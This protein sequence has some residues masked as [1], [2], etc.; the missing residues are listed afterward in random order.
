[1]DQPFVQPSLFLEPPPGIVERIWDAVDR[2]YAAG[3]KDPP[4]RD[5]VVEFMRRVAP[6]EPYSLS[7]LDRARMKYRQWLEPWPIR[8]GQRRPW[9][10]PKS[11]VHGV[12]AQ[13]TE[14]NG[15]VHADWVRLTCSI[16]ANGTFADFN[17]MF[18]FVLGYS[19]E[20]LLHA[21]VKPLLRPNEDTKVTE[22][23]T[24]R[25][26]A[27]LRSGESDVE[28]ISGWMQAKNGQRIEISGTR[29][30]WST[31]YQRWDLVSQIAV[32]DLPLQTLPF[33]GSHRPEN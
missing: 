17:D 7:T 22:A 29:V 15:Q 12:V 4:K 18:A 14:R 26:L 10:Q 27:A 32:A 28:T 11:L 5:E 21:A 24:V 31:E 3:K 8:R 23:E 30:T 33:F 19:R 25:K 2:W 13:R 16:A 1:M 20:E 9:Q 6:D